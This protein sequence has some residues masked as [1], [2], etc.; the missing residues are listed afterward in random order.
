MCRREGLSLCLY[1]TLPHQCTRLSVSGLQVCKIL[2]VSSECLRMCPIVIVQGT[3]REAV[4]PS[5][6]LRGG[7]RWGQKCEDSLLRALGPWAPLLPSNL[8]L[9]P[10]LSVRL[11]RC[12][13]PRCPPTGTPYALQP[14]C[15][16]S[17]GSWTGFSDGVRGCVVAPDP[18]FFAQPAPGDAREAWLA[19]VTPVWARGRAG[20][21]QGHCTSSGGAAR[22]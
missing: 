8:P 14:G 6:K 12:H 7:R 1:V 19:L 3:V 17:C 15:L 4:R 13:N 9:C 20:R 10:F 16:F 22:L 21:S 18:G 5:A 11:P 2:L